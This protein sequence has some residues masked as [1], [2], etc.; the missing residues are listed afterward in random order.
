MATCGE[1]STKSSVLPELPA[2]LTQKH[3][4]LVLFGQRLSPHESRRFIEIVAFRGDLRPQF[5]YY[6]RCMSRHTAGCRDVYDAD[7]RWGGRSLTL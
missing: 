2:K 4:A 6:T 7:R 1:K 3:P 5:D